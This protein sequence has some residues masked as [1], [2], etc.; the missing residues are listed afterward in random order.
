MAS[1]LGRA[2]DAHRIIFMA[3]APSFSSFNAS[4]PLAGAPVDRNATRPAWAMYAF[5]ISRRV[6]KVSV[7]KPV[8]PRR[9]CVW[10]PS[11]DAA[12]AGAGASRDELCRPVRLRPGE[13]WFGRGWPRRDEIADF[14]ETL[15]NALKTGG[16]MTLAL[17]MAARMARTPRMRGIVGAL[18]DRIVHGEELHVAMRRF[19]QVFTPMQ[20]AMVEAAS[21]TGL[22]RAGDLLVTL[23]GRL[24]RDGRIL[25]KFLGTLSY[26]L[27]LLALTIVGAI[28][29]EIWALPPMVELFR[30]LGGRLPPITRDFYLV[31]QFLRT[32]ALLVF[33][34]AIG[35]GIAAIALTPKVLQTRW[36]QR[37]AVRAWL[38]GPVIQWMAL[39]RAL[40]TFILLKQSGARVKDQFSLAA[41]AAGNCVVG[42]F[43]ESCYARIALGESVEEAFAAE[44]HRL[45]DDG[46][47]IAGKMEVGM[48][49]ADLSV[50]VNRIVDELNDRAEHRLNL[51]PNMIRW[52]LLIVCCTLIGIVAL[53]IVL[54]YPNLIADVARQ[55]ADYAAH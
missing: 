1:C 37:C 9:V 45:G 52:P 35:A 49:G 13:G 20:L 25:R 44:R 19:P 43:F 8:P 34:S 14:Y 30:T 41:A 7:G 26:P 40:A 53:A 46:L 23:S 5:E 55:Q 54:P 6:G 48:A 2:A 12:L 28:V 32:H 3:T 11:A 51:L 47:R 50:L 39:V 38:I 15:G 27:S 31:A 29:L 16:G 10:A 36:A 42:E 33:P 21:A 18:Y 24:Q 17:G 22:D 4:V